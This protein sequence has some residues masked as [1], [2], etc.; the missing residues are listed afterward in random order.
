MTANKMFLVEELGIR[1]IFIFKYKNKNMSYYPKSQIK[2]N[3]YTNG[4]E[5]ILSTKKQYKGYY[6]KVPM[7]KYTWK[8]PKINLIFYYTHSRQNL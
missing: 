6:Y 1:I 7:E 4:G 8:T 2:T 5:F 3:L